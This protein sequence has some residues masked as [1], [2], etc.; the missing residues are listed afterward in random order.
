[1]VEEYEE[2]IKDWY[3]KH[4][5]KVSLTMYLYERQILKSNE[6]CK[7]FPIQNIFSL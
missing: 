5:Y 2:S 3:M 4:K 7:N 1:M 6:K